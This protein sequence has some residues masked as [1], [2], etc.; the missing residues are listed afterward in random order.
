M[1]KTKKRQNTDEVTSEQLCQIIVNGMQER[2]A[3]DIVIMDLRK[4]KSA[5]TDFFVIASGTSDTQIDSI[6]DSVEEEVW[7]ATQTH[8]FGREGKVQKE[9]VL[10]DYIDVVAHIFKKDRREFFKLEELWGDAEFT[11]LP[12]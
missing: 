12:N 2:K 5:I 4:V 8:P 7:K 6:A 9:W 11:Y 10:V 3:Q 1:A